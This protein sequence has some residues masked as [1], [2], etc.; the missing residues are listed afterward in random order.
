MA[1]Q[2]AKTQ[3]LRKS[4]VTENITQ[5]ETHLYP[6]ELAEDHWTQ[7]NDKRSA[8]WLSKVSGEEVALGQKRLAIAPEIKRLFEKFSA[9]TKNADPQDISRDTM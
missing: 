9:L 1:A 6:F 4:N 7:R 8:A 5:G 2:I 3:L